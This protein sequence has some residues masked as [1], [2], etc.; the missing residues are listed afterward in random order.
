MTEGGEGRAAG[1]WMGKLRYHIF[2]PKKEVEKVTL[3]VEWRSSPM[4]NVLQ[5]GVLP[6]SECSITSPKQHHQLLM[7]E[8]SRL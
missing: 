6:N 2:G 8:M 3:E 5:Q 4:T 1:S 7:M